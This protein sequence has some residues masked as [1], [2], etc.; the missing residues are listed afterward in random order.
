MHSHSSNGITWMNLTHTMNV[1][2]I[3]CTISTAPNIAKLCHVNIHISNDI[4][5]DALNLE[6]G[7]W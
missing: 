7:M 5:L 6:F 3:G 1:C 2:T 4:I